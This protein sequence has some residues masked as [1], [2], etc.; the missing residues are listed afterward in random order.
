L[1]IVTNHVKVVAFGSQK[2]LPVTDVLAV[3]MAISQLLIL[4]TSCLGFSK[5]FR[6]LLDQ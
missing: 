6:G 4:Q 1:Y 3:R 5:R 2:L